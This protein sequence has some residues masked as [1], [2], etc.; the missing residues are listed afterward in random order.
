[1]SM[2]A[3]RWQRIKQLF[4]QAVELPKAQRATFAETAAFAQ[5]FEPDMLRDVLSLLEA[6]ETQPADAGMLDVAPDL[7]GEFSAEARAQA[8]H[9]LIGTSVG[10]WTL[11]RPIGQGGMG[12][13]YLA[14]RSSGDFQQQAAVKLIRPGFDHGL[15]QRFRDERRILAALNHG[16]IARL[17]DGGESVDGKPYLAMEYVDGQPLDVWCDTQTLGVR[18]RVQLFVQVCSAVAHAH[19]ALVVHR[20]LKP[21]NI[22]VDADGQVKLLDFGIAKL[23]SPTAINQTGSGT[24]LFTPEYAAPEQVRGEPTTTS[25][26][27]YALGLLLYELLTG[28]RAYGRSAATP[29]AYEHA[30]LSELPTQPSNAVA[31]TD[32][33]SIN[34]AQ[35]RDL[36][37]PRLREL[38]RGDLD[39]IVMQA[40]RKDP[41]ERYG[42]VEAMVADLERYLRHEPVHARRGNLRYRAQRFFERHVLAVSLSTVAVLSLLAGLGV[43]LWQADV[44]RAERNE[45]RLQALTASRTVEFMRTLFEL[46]DPSESMGRSITAVEILERGVT[47]IE[48]RLQDEPAVR[49]TLLR[50]L[51]EA[52]LGLGIEK[53]ARTL[54]ESALQQ[55]RETGDPMLVGYAIGSLSSALSRLG[56]EQAALELLQDAQNLNLP[57]DPAGEELRARLQIKLAIRLSARSEHAAA[58]PL[59]RSGMQRLKRATGRIDPEIAIPFSALLHATSRVPEAEVLLREALAEVERSTPPGHTSRAAVSAQLATNL[60]RQDRIEESLPLQLQALQTKIAIYGPN[61]QS[62]DITRQNLAGALSLLGRWDESEKLNREVL[63]SM[64]QRYGEAHPTVAASNASLART[65]LNS[66]RAQESEAYWRAALASAEQHYGA[67]DNATAITTL[68]LGRCLLE[69][70]RFDE[71]IAAL[72][73]ASTAYRS[74]GVH[75]QR[76]AARVDLE[77]TRVWLARADTTPDCSLAETAQSAWPAGSSDHAYAQL[78]FGACLRQLKQEPRGTTL[79]ES[80]TRTLRETRSEVWPERRYAETLLAK[81]IQPATH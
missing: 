1:M 48:T 4:E 22:L 40:L 39:A 10:P 41:G 81:P 2:S 31:L 8:A 12:T 36:S 16:A 23:L 73:R 74:H 46:A 43:A 7:L 61:H 57:D 18:A 49:S 20:D 59:F 58:E 60:I 5:N 26:D 27:I 6:D 37:A 38:L 56:E 66:G 14:Q 34:L 50:A 42:S 30:I 44:A 9:A 21:S 24:R 29:A 53:R 15:Q 72:E 69:L 71:A 63:N 68:G 77:R 33:Q 55:A 25:V 52:H 11:L 67:H 78:V 28:R 35:R 80:A 65:L 70:G 76:G 45:A 17:L 75:G 19:R 47:Q 64:T 51:G 54:M 62:V 3:E 79:I 32:E 13:V